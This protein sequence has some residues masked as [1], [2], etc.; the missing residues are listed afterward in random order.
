MS[1]IF[2]RQRSDRR[3]RVHA[4]GLLNA[5]AGYYDFTARFI[6][7]A[8]LCLCERGCGQSRGNG[9]SRLHTASH[10]FPPAFL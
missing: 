7:F 8:L 3:R 6:L 2:R 10:R 9:N 4:R 1:A 5:R